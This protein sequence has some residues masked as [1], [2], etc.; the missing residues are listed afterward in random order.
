MSNRLSG[1]EGGGSVGGR[2]A[3]NSCTHVPACSST[4][5]ARGGGG[6]DDELPSAGTLRLTATVM[7]PDV[8]ISA[9]HGRDMSPG[10]VWAPDALRGDPGRTEPRTSGGLLQTSSPPIDSPLKKVAA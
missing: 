3:G 2:V 8:E 7:R 6:A 9:A 1:G 4:D 10:R 5:S